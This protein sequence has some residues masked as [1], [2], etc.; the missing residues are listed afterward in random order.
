V[1][2]VAVWLAEDN[3]VRELQH[4][5]CDLALNPEDDCLVREPAARALLDIGDED[6]IARLRPLALGQAGDDP[7]DELKGCALIALWPDHFTA[8]ELFASLTRPNN[9]NFY[10][11]YRLFLSNHLMKRA[12]PSHLPSALR[13]VQQ[14]KTQDPLVFPFGSLVESVMAHAWDQLDSPGVLD[15]FARAALYRLDNFGEI[16]PRGSRGPKG[17][18]L[19]EDDRKRRYLA[20]KMIDLSSESPGTAFS[21]AYLISEVISRQ[22]HSWL[23]EMFDQLPNGKRQEVIGWLISMFF[24]SVD[25]ELF[26]KLFDLSEQNKVFGEAF[27]RHRDPIELASKEAQSL[28]KVYYGKQRGRQPERLETHSQRLPEEIISRELDGIERHGASRFPMLVQQ[29]IGAATGSGGYHS[30]PSS[31]TVLQAWR[32]TNEKAKARIIRAAYRYVVEGEPDTS[33]WIGTGR[34]TWTLW[35]GYYALR[36]IRDEFRQALADL[37]DKVLQK[38]SPAVI[39]CSQ[40]EEDSGSADLI[41]LL[42]KRI[43]EEMISS[44]M[45]QIE[46][47]NRKSGYLSVL[48]KLAPCWDDRLADALTAK[49]KDRQ[50]TPVVVES[51]LQVLLKRG[52]SE[53]VDF[54]KAQLEFP[55]L[56]SGTARDAPLVAA[57]SLMLHTP[58]EGWSKVW[59]VMTENRIFGRQLV[60]QLAEEPNFRVGKMFD[61]FTE[62][63]L[64]SLYIWISREFPPADD[65]HSLRLS[66]AVGPRDLC[67]SILKHLQDRGTDGVLKALG[68]L[69]TEIPDQAQDLIWT[70]ALAKDQLLTTTW[71]PWK[72]KEILGTVTDHSQRLV[73]SGRQLLEVVMESLERLQKLLHG[74][75][76][77]VRDLWDKRVGKTKRG[78]KRAELQDENHEND[79]DSWRPVQE[80]DLSDRIARHLRDDLQ[81]R[82]I[83]IGREVQI[84]RGEQ[85]D[86]HVDALSED[87]HSDR[88]D[89]VKVIIEV[90]GCW[91]DGI[92]RDMQEQLVGRYLSKSDCDY[93]LYLVG[94]FHCDQWDEDD[95]RRKRPRKANYEMSVADAQA[96]FDEQAEQVS[97]CAGKVVRA[98]VLDVGLRQNLDTSKSR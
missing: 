23:I 77:A 12:S 78:R 90:K 79:P 76:P 54:A 26:A 65:S 68:R 56:D 4:V 7:D 41:P 74:E 86:I 95:R 53:A 17:S 28:R 20:E 35:A 98:L 62:D 97:Q 19:F 2:R 15:E 9:P 22:D 75:I 94:W 1:R 49:M 55:L 42:Y 38:W 71:T 64:A 11:A 43:P 67:Q 14:Q 44:L 61:Q 50:L 63:H 5:I 29:M 39:V 83:V 60:S 81:G 18:I 96:R 40:T 45:V 80:P 66:H 13:W 93:G 82:G 6:V 70:L 91:N 69:Q 32:S 8:E 72:P 51:L 52:V 24:D 88:L 48:D 31:L 25:T 92:D 30:M 85:T 21:L 34:I 87:S 57:K 47:E 89:L 73:Q 3:G 46:V 84:R 27:R 37:P 33:Q 10:G 16:V 58:E 59:S 36:L